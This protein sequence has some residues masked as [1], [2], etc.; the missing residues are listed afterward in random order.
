MIY[1]LV[2]GTNRSSLIEKIF[3]STSN[4]FKIWRGLK[5]NLKHQKKDAS[6]VKSKEMESKQDDLELLRLSK[7]HSKNYIRQTNDWNNC[8]GCW[9]WYQHL[10][11]VI[12]WRR[13]R[14]ISAYRLKN[15]KK[16]IAAMTKRLSRAKQLRNR[17]ICS[18]TEEEAPTE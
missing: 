12:Y 9:D 17:T 10:C 16:L 18:M 6:K 3:F 13:Y 4:C 15:E 1:H 7:D 5:C 11:A 14:P 8:F 2:K